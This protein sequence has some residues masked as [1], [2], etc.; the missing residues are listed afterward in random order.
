MIHHGHTYFF[1]ITA[2]LSS[3]QEVFLIVTCPESVPLMRNE[4]D[5][6]SRLEVSFHLYLTKSPS[7]TTTVNH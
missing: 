4:E 2:D 3:D 7:L 6:K 5:V 1:P